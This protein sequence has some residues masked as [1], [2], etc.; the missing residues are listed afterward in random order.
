MG[1]AIAPDG[2]IYVAD[3]GNSRI[4]HLDVQGNILTTL[5]SHTPDGQQPPGPARV[6][7]R[8]GIAVAAQGNV[9]VAD[10]WNNRVQK[11]DDK[12]FCN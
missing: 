9:Y 6:N 5:G 7:E 3:T 12:G 4:V 8:W 11:F 2:P 10:T 1:V